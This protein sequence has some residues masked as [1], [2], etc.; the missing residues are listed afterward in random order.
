MI[1]KAMLLAGLYLS[2]AA[3]SGEQ[4][5]TTE[6]RPVDWI[7]VGKNSA[8]GDQTSNVF[9]GRV[10]A[11]QSTLVSFEVEG[12]IA[13]MPF[14]IGDAFRSGAALARVD[15]NVYRL[16]L[17]E[18]RAQLTETEARAIEADLNLDRTKD[19]FERKAASKAE[20]ERAQA[21]SDS[22]NGLAAAAKA[23]VGLANDALSDSAI[24]APFAGRVARRM[25]EPGAQ[26]RPGEPVLEIDGLGL[27]VSF[28]VSRAIR[29][30]LKTGDPVSVFLGSNDAQS[31]P[32]SIAELSSRATGVGAYEIV[33]NIPSLDETFRPGSVVDIRLDPSWPSRGEQTEIMIPITA[34]RPG[35]ASKGSV[36]VIDPETSIVSARPVTLG[37]ISGDFVAVTDGLKQGELIVKRGVA[38]VTD[39]EPVAR[40]GL[41][42]QRYSK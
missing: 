6:P 34:F 28:T 26:V 14:E 40:I 36:M 27:E 33:A 25:V 8:S 15:R 2:V 42:S 11:R 32:G 5:F 10:Q 38:F 21:T 35:E 37:R 23:R 39:G 29:D 19:L 13:S 4:T 7:E 16:R 1:K 22:L 12:R 9:P 30:R 31:V 17:A 3:C 18:A 20:F 24:R 41:G